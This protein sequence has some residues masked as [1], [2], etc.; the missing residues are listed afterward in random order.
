M[1][2]FGGTCCVRVESEMCSSGSARQDGSRERIPRLGVVMETRIS[3]MCCSLCSHSVNKACQFV[4][5]P[6][7][8]NTFDYSPE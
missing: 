7:W 4:L 1:D 3:S 8:R 5:S 2:Y 6:S